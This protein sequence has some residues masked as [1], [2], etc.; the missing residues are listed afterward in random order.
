ME[1]PLGPLC[2]LAL[3]VA[4]PWL[5]FP[6][7]GEWVVLRLVRWEW[8]C[9]M[10]CWVFSCL[11]YLYPLRL[12]SWATVRGRIVPAR[13]AVPPNHHHYRCLDGVQL[14]DLWLVC[15]VRHR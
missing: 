10:G 14:L 3:R 9:V 4:I 7:L 5:P 1:A 8:V 13:V 15:G 2:L 12:A 11:L 6:L